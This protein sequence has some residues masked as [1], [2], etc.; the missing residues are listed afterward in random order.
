MPGWA[1]WHERIGKDKELSMYVLELAFGDD[2]A[3]LEARPEHR[4]L[5]QQLRDEGVLVMAG[6]FADESG[7][8]L[9]F[10]VPDMDTLDKV[11]QRDPYY[12]APGV[13]IVSR[14]EWSPIIT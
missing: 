11:I 5:L 10:D 3:R 9:I 4:R 2:P 7:A 8:L 1:C 14:R 13:T 12:Q 6:P